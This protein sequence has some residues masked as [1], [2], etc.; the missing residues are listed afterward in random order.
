MSTYERFDP[1][2]RSSV[3]LQVSLLVEALVAV[4]HA[5]LVSFSWLWTRLRLFLLHFMSVLRWLEFRVTHLD[6]LWT[7]GRGRLL[8]LYR[9]H[10]G[11]DISG[12]I[13][14]ASFSRIRA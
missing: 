9:P 2:V 3:N 12:E 8:S 1:G 5:A 7:L 11:I 10:E 13:D 4:G 6:G 14:A